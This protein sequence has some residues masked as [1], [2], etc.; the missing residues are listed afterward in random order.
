MISL[1]PALVVAAPAVFHFPP[2]VSPLPSFIAM[3]IQQQR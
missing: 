2:L 3:S 1:P